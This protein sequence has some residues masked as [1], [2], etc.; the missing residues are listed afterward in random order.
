MDDQTSSFRAALHRTD[1]LMAISFR[2]PPVEEVVCDVRFEPLA[3]LRLTHFGLLWQRFRDSYPKVEHAPP[4][5]TDLGDM[6]I[7]P[8][9]GGPLPRVWF[10][11][12]SDDYLIQF[13]PDHLIFNW[14]RREQKYPRFSEVFP[15]FRGCVETFIAFLSEY[16]LGPIKIRA[17]EL[18]YINQIPKGEGWE[19]PSDACNVFKDFKWAHASG[20]FLPNPD[21]NS[22][23]AAFLM[24][25]D[26]GM[27]ITRVRQGKRSADGVPLILFDLVAR[28]AGP[29]KSIEE[30]DSWFELAH[31]WIVNGF[32]DLTNEQ[33]QSAIWEREDATV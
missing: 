6:H 13:Q 19:T 21:T 20:R 24:P 9:T 28:G 14:R 5:I 29:N 7:D 27:L 1:L 17:F 18:T 23:Q 26:S 22:W 3:D 8:A 31:T 12:E 16:G 30:L 33:I 15:R 4:L 11:A 2:K 25:E 10:I 32:A